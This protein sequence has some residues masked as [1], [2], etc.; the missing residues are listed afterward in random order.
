MQEIKI[1]QNQKNKSKNHFNVKQLNAGKQN[2]C[3][4]EVIKLSLE[5]K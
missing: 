4:A 1:M 2:F 5:E 3:F